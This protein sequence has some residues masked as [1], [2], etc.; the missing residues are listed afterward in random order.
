MNHLVVVVVDPP[1][2]GGGESSDCGQMSKDE[3]ADRD[4]GRRGLVVTDVNS[5][6]NGVEDEPHQCTDSRSRVNYSRASVAAGEV[7]AGLLT[8]TQA[9]NTGGPAAEPQRSESGEREDGEQ[10]VDN[11]QC[12]R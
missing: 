4:G 5:D 11:L 2:V 9:V 1:P 10:R 6:L 12:R 8:S 3:I 7:R